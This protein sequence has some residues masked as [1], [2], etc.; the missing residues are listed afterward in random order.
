MNTREALFDFAPGATPP[1]TLAPA[2][3]GAPFT[4]IRATAEACL[5]AGADVLHL[6]VMD[7]HFVPEI[8]FGA[9]LIAELRDRLP[10]TA[11]LDV[12]LLCIEADRQIERFIEAGADVLSF[13]LETSRNPFRS[14]EKIRAQGRRAGVALLPATPLSAIEEML[15]LLDLV[16]VMTVHPGESRLL[17]PMLGK[18]ARLREMVARS[19]RAVRICA[20]GGVKRETAGTIAGHGADWLVAASAVFAD[21]DVAGNIAALRARA[22][23]ARP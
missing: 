7:G 16:I 20:D 23:E 9:K 2:L 22:A 1:T 6:D 11:I 14:L 5:S 10:Q 4:D 17:E 21:G 12:H 13:P 18:L 19:R 15:P 8:T 3:L